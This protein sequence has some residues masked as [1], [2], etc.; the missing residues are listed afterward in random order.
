MVYT[1]KVYVKKRIYK[2]RK[3]AYRKR[4]MGRKG[5]GYDGSYKVKL[6]YNLP[7]ENHTTWSNAPQTGAKVEVAWGLSAAQSSVY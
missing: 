3:K 1:K 5:P 6:Q 7:L 4:K 2:K